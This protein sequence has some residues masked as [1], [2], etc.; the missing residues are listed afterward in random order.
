MSL[1]RKTKSHGIHGFE[2]NYVNIDQAWSNGLGFA[3]GFGISTFRL[4][5]NLPVL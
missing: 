4:S 3:S 2:K 1:C 5:L